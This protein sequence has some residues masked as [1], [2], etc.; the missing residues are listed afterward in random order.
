MHDDWAIGGALM[1]N[2]SPKALRE[3]LE[4]VPTGTRRYGPIAGCSKNRFSAD[5][6][7]QRTPGRKSCY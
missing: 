3:P 6:P 4:R 1:M 2:G 5:E 7:L